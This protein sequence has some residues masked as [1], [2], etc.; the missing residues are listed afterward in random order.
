M[1]LRWSPEE[2]EFR[3]EARAY[4]EAN[5]PKDLSDDEET[6]EER[7]TWQKKLADDRWVAIHWPAEYGGR[8]ANLIQTVIYNEEYTRS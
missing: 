4:L 7:R 3:Q 8:G 5:A 2:E 6:F 1:D